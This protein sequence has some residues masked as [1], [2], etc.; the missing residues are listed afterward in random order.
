MRRWLVGAAVLGGLALAVTSIDRPGPPPPGADPVYAE[1]SALL[2]DA[3]DVTS[4]GLKVPVE[5]A[6]PRLARVGLGAWMQTLPLDPAVRARIDARLGASGFV[7]ELVPFALFVK[8]MYEA[9]AVPDFATW[10]RA[11]VKP[12]AGVPGYEHS[13]F[14][15]TPPAEEAGGGPAIPPEMAARLLELY[16]AVYLQDKPAG[17]SVEERLACEIVDDAALAA[18]SKRAAPI[19]R[20]LLRTVEAGMDPGDMKDAVGHVLRDDTTLEAVTLTLIEFVDGEVCKHY[21]I[22]SARTQRERQLSAWLS[23]ALLTPGRADGWVWL[24]WH[25]GRRHAV[26]VVVDGLQGH[27]VSALARGQAED[28]FLTRL[29]AEE[30]AERGAKPK[31]KSAT[32]AP[33]MSTGFL[34]HAAK[35]GTPGLLPYLARVVASPGFA[36]QGISTTPT[37]SVRN[38]PIAKT[39]AP[40]AGAGATGVPNFHFVDRGYTLDGVQQG[41]PW[42][43]YGNDALQLTALTRQ[44]GMK[45]MFERL[46]RLVTMSCGAQYDE[47]ARYSFDSFL[48]LAVGE[49]SRDFG[50][51]RCVGELQRRAANELRMAEIRANLLAREPLLRAEHAP[52]EWYDRWG[53]AKEADAVRALVAEL[54]S[55]EGAGLPDYLLYYNPWPDHFAHG[56][57]PFS[58]EIIGPTGELVRLDHWL[59]AVADA[60]TQGGVA[61]R[62]LFGMAGDHGLTPVHWIVSPEQEFIAGLEKSGVKLLVKKI[63][64]DEGEGPKLTHRLRPPGM[65]GYDLVVASTAG[66]NYMLDFFVDQGENWARQ[67]VLAELRTLRTIGGKTVDVIA[68]LNSRLGDSLDYLVVR[69]TPCTPEGGIIQVMGPRDGGTA[70]GTIERRDDRIW[71]GWAGADVLGLGDLSAFDVDDTARTRIAA[72]RDRCL[73]APRSD[74]TQWCTEDEW[75]TATQLGR[76]PDSVTQ[77]AH[78]YDTD[79]AGTVNLFPRDGVGYNTKVPGRHA[80]E[81]FHEKDAFVGIWGAP[82]NGSARVDIALN[83]AVPMAMYSWVTGER[84]VS[85]EDGWG[86]TPL[87]E[88]LL[89]DR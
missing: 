2:R 79:R 34:A 87:P 57:G 47:V 26:H 75:R 29:V 16:D 19:V 84:P 50:D 55:L 21:R 71:Y 32:A 54:A 51:V 41:R 70:V 15:F 35:A 61:E 30:A 36:R 73:A 77:L 14:T 82:V 56:K 27:L 89:A 48:S 81:S 37:I 88:G 76:R 10:A 69:E 43:F 22:F 11:N 68:E 7:D 65:R 53:Q 67:P 58:D 45:T 12:A 31:L 40:V 4:W 17:A 9:P 72:L 86:Y 42:Y 1:V 5:W 6:G 85:G 33:G 64:S 38:L 46:D 80:G 39:G 13:L 83:G 74:R 3:Y 25:G 66:G 52:W 18:R 44:A 24:R 63:S 8:E 78:L 20:E 23:D 59:A 62:T 28:P 60:Y 49:A